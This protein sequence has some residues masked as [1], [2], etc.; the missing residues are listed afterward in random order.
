VYN[1]IPQHLGTLSLSESIEVSNIPLVALEEVDRTS[2]GNGIT[3]AS[4]ADAE[5]L[6]HQL[7]LRST[8][9]NPDVSPCS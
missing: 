1:G 5:D 7:Y 4:Q 9:C 2:L 8:L 3:V 6:L